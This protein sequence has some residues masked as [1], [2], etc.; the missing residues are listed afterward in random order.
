M[1]EKLPPKI[2]VIEPDDVLRNVIS[3]TI[4]RYWFNVIRLGELDNANRIVF[5][6]KPH[7]IVI[8]SKA[9]YIFKIAKGIRG[10]EGFTNIPLILILNEKENEVDYN[11]LNHNLIELIFRPF[12]TSEIMT[13]IKS[14]LRK[15]QPILQDKIIKYKDVSI[16]LA[17]FKVYRGTRRVHVGPTEFKILQLLMQS[18]KS[19]FSRQQVIDYVWGPNYKIEL[20]TVDVHINRLRTL[21]KEENEKTA[22][23]KTIRS[24]GYCLVLPGDNN[25]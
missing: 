18:P 23:I 1:S 12:T 7:L 13:A 6:N 20:R 4:E 16:D 11:Q 15:S 19:I 8:S 14:L 21:I 25:A 9:G 5:V 3:N 22:F 17:A 24:A 10:M 2:L